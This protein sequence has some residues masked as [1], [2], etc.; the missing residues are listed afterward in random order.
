MSTRYYEKNKERL[1]KRLVK[2]IKNFL[3]KRKKKSF[4]IVV[5]DVEIFQKMKSKG[6][7]KV[8]EIIIYF[9]KK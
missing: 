8:A 1:R 4:S 2:D 3:K 5:N 9:I 7:Q 6:Q